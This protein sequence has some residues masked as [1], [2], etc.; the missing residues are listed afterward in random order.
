[1]SLLTPVLTCTAPMLNP[2]RKR[3]KKIWK[4]KTTNSRNNDYYTHIHSGLV[5]FSH[6]LLDLQPAEQLLKSYHGHWDQPGHK[7]KQQLLL[8]FC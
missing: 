2:L 5:L 7:M 8:N 6:L 4:I 3:R 1:M